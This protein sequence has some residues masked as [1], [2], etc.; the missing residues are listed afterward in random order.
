MAFLNKVTFCKFPEP[1]E[2]PGQLTFWAR[3]VS[4]VST[5]YILLTDGAVAIEAKTI[6]ALVD[7]FN[8]YD[9]VGLVSPKIVVDNSVQ[10][11]LDT[12]NDTNNFCKALR[13]QVDRDAPNMSFTQQVNSLDSTLVMITREAWHSINS[14]VELY[15]DLRHFVLDL[16]LRVR[17]RGYRCLYVPAV[18]VFYQDSMRD[19][20]LEK[21]CG[22]VAAE[23]NRLK[24]KARWK[25]P[26]IGKHKTEAISAVKSVREEAKRCLF[27]DFDTPRPDINAG[28]YAAVKEMQILQSLG[29]RVTFIPKN[30]D[31]AGPY[32]EALQ[33]MGIECIYAPFFVTMDEFLNNQ[34]REFVLIYI[35]RYHVA[36]DVLPLLRKYVPTIKVVLMLADLHFLRELRSALFNKDDEQLSRA[37]ETRESEL[38][39]MRK[40][41]LVL[42]YSD[43]ERAVILSHNLATTKVAKCPWVC[44]AV[45][46]V[47]RFEHRVDIAFIGGFNHSPNL[48]AM[49]WFIGKVWPSLLKQL[50]EVQL[51]IYGSAI[52]QGLHD[53]V[54][55]DERILVHGWVSDVATV[56]ETCRVFIAPLQSGA[57]IKGKV[58]G[59]LSYGV[60]SVLSN[61]AVEGIGVCDGVHAF[62]ARSP[63]EWV[64]RIVS[65]YTDQEQW[66]K[67]SQYAHGFAKR[68]YSLNNGVLEMETA[69]TT[70]GIDPCLSSNFL[71][72]KGLASFVA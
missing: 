20:S 13:D 16:S 6:E 55:V 70:I 45:E 27:L 57:G 23:I 14:F 21:K 36:H 72:R 69:L 2:E 39:V 41:D 66:K 49:T 44:E 26:A 59:A 62:I 32:T 10:T 58:V 60:P 48:E 34:S 5:E 40:V 19:E 29:Y 8:E 4:G 12:F 3:G 1:D 15:P 71:I 64:S 46:V 65:L 30:F 37:I 47:S 43:V 56:Y 68:H 61:V 33:R 31:H 53:L 52:P 25:V 54:S 67:I 38:A 63:D 22:G 28:G 24:L 35:T 9:Q 51:R 17:E 7:V 11:Y 42:S 18:E 50:P